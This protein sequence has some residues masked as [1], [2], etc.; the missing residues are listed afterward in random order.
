MN[1]G[2]CELKVCVIYILYLLD[3]VVGVIFE[4]VIFNMI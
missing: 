4:S 2:N 1:V 3:F